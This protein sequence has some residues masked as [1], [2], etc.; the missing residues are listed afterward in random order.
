MH[1][2]A[3]EKGPG[4]RQRPR[5]EHTQR[6]R[7]REREREKRR[8]RASRRNGAK[9]R[10]KEGRGGRKEEAD[11]GGRRWRRLLSCRANE[12]LT[13][14]IVGWRKQFANVNTCWILSAWGPDEWELEGPH[15]LPPVYPLNLWL[16]P[17]P[18]SS[19]TYRHRAHTP[20]TSDVH[21]WSKELLA[22]S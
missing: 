14:F 15:T 22:G 19:S 5:L 10:L 3:K 7:E 20:Y 2:R 18:S 17:P 9:V 12:I 13:D 11:E 21:C 6:E 8:R 16:L 4:S 1:T